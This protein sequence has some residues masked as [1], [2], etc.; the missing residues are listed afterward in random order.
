MSS[1]TGTD[2]SLKIIDST[3]EATA[4]DNTLV[5]GREEAGAPQ[6]SQGNPKSHGN[7]P[8]ASEEEPRLGA[9][10]ARNPGSVGALGER[11]T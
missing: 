7:L 11:R 4:D 10:T 8:E 2:K 6:Q 3:V 5:Q 1:D 9:A